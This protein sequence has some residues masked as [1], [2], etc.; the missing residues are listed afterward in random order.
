M[1]KQKTK[2]PNQ[3]KAFFHCKKCI[4]EKPYDQS[5]QSWQRIQAGWTVKGLQVWCT[6]HDCDVMN[7]DFLGQK[8]SYSDNTEI[9]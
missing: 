7:L 5:P 9:D 6:R 2:M 8:I 4:V 1:A 3:I